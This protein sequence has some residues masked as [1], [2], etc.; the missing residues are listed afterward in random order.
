MK[1]EMLPFD[2]NLLDLHG[3]NTPPKSSENEFT[4]NYSLG[5]RIQ[6]SMSAPPVAEHVG[7]LPTPMYAQSEYDDNQMESNLHPEYYY[8]YAPKS[9]NPRLPMSY[10]AW[11]SMHKQYQSR[12]HNSSSLHRVQIPEHLDNI[13]GYTPSG[14]QKASQEDFEAAVAAVGG[15]TYHDVATKQDS[16]CGSPTESSN[17]DSGGSVR[18]VNKTLIDRIQEDFPRTPSPVFGY[19]LTSDMEDDLQRTLRYHDTNNESDF[20]QGMKRHHNSREQLKQRP[21][22]MNQSYYPMMYPP[23]PGIP[24]AIPPSHHGSN[25]AVMQSSYERYARG[26]PQESLHYND[27]PPYRELPTRE[28][29]Y[30]NVP[31]SRL[32]DKPLYGHSYPRDSPPG[33]GNQQSFMDESLDMQDA[34][35]YSVPLPRT[36][37]GAPREVE[38][39]KVSNVRGPLN[40]RHELKEGYFEARP[41]ISTEKPTRSIEKSKSLGNG[42]STGG[43]QSTSPALPRSVLLDEFR[44]TT[45]TKKWELIDARGHI[46]EFAK[47]QHGSRFIQQKLETAK[48]DIKDIVF[49]EIYPVALSLMTDVFGNYVIQKFF[50][51]GNPEHLLLLLRTITG[52][53]LELALQ[54]YGCRVIQKAL[55]LKGTPEKLE[56]ISELQGH[57]LKC[58]K[59]QNGNHVI[60]KCIEILPWKASA[61]GS[62][63]RSIERGN[64]ILSAF[65]GNVYS[66]ATHP[67]GCRV[68][69]RV[70][71]NCS[72]AQMAPIL[73][74]I[75]D[76]CC[77]LVEDQYGNYVIQHVLEHGQPCERAMVINKVYPD[78]VRFSYHKFASN[79][80]EKCLMYASVNQ[81]H[82]IVQHVMEPNEHGE[83]PLQVMMKDQYANYVVQKL[84]DVADAEEREQMVVII[85]TQASHLKRF[86]FG[87]HILNRL[88]K[89]TG[90]KIA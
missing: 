61:S 70:L 69:Q 78:I 71:E 35:A 24:F 80:I 48:A 88:E 75:H 14:A 41:P 20:L 77:L 73:K 74:E 79:V 27:Y 40:A 5:S 3:K 13:T 49:S 44:A 39:S 62:H 45:K 64:F 26:F 84:I 55:E 36:S 43:N 15:H 17:S 31:D 28:R 11:E 56:L 66:L 52:R 76:C 1:S 7:R 42:S 82:V 67:Y 83:C 2:M 53:V 10:N 21:S 18:P 60:Q 9:H 38:S 33:Y 29:D 37:S 22:I 46:V 25:H 23:P 86:N 4:K 12:F 72:E 30:E 90:Q 81:L 68:I 87:K 89:L 54:M 47:D 85:K 8:Y 65:V 58:V 57:V 6:R 32:R 50:D 63:Q 16:Y 19:G 34:K 51:Y 59:D